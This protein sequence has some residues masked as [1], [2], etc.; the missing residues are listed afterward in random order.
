MVFL[1]ALGRVVLPKIM[2][3][4]VDADDGQI[5]GFVVA[6]FGGSTAHSDLCGA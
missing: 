5:L 3:F 4:A 6:V 1:A 2:V